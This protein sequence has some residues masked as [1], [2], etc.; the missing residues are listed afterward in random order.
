MNEVAT[1]YNAG[2]TG[3]LARLTSEYGGTPQAGFPTPEP[4]DGDEIFPEA[5]VNASGTNFTEIRL[6]LNNRSGWPARMGDRLS[7]RYFFTLEPGVTPGQIT[8]TANFN[9]CTAPQAPVQFSGSIYSI[10][11]SCLGVK[12]Y[13]G[14]QSNY[15]KEVQF[16]IASSGAWDPTND[17]SFT[18]RPRRR[19]RRRSRSPASPCT[20]TGSASSDGAGRRR[21]PAA[22]DAGQ[23]ARHRHHQH[24]GGARLER[25]HRQRGRHRLP[26]LPRHDARGEPD[27]P[28]VHRHRLAPSTTYSYTVRA[29]DAAGN[30]SAASSAVSATTGPPVPDTQA[31]TAPANLAVSGKTSSTVS[32]AW[33][34]STDNVGVTGY[35]VLEGTTQVGTSATTVL[36]RDRAGRVLDATPTPCAR[37]T[38]P[39]TCP[40][41][42]TR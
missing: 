20:T 9:Q 37:W 36:H 27:R 6:Y 38:R 34:A 2:L 35:R 40:R 1:D 19:A 24:D 28:R 26:A 21:H 3:A 29:V 30:Q 33:S 41:P 23:P 42:A 16:R 12:I 11:V 8:L 32:L 18:G 10:T 25:G 39:R 31:P 13:P 5:A 14:G 7:F 4:T 22:V 17:W 15:R